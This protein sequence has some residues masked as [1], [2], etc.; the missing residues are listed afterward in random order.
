MAYLDRLLSADEK[1]LAQQRL[2]WAVFISSAVGL[3]IQGAIFYALYRAFHAL[4]APSDPSTWLQHLPPEARQ[5]VRQI[6]LQAPE[7]FEKISKGIVLLYVFIAAT[8]VLKTVLV[9]MTSLTVITN[10]R[11]IQVH[12]LISKTVV[13]SSLEKINDVL[14]QQPLLG[15]LLG[16]GTVVVMT[17]S[18]T[19]LNRMVFLKNPVDFKRV[20][21]DAKRGLSGGGAPIAAEPVNMKKLDASDRL[22]ELGDLRKS[23]LISADE[24]DKKRRAILDE[25]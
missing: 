12:G 16:Y 23:G 10:L 20:M 6:A 7:V 17:A 3:V 4:A 14:L 8:T 15:R 19:G 5:A 13:D 9:W 11:V 22:A 2:H 24:Y 1:I 21:M 25:L 18:E